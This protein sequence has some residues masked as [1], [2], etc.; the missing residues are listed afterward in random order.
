[1]PGSKEKG[2]VRTRK[3]IPWDVIIIGIITIIML[4]YV[5]IY[6]YYQEMQL[7]YDWTRD[8]LY[9]TQT[10]IARSLIKHRLRILPLFS[11]PFSKVYPPHYHLHPVSEKEKICFKNCYQTWNRIKSADHVVGE[12]ETMVPYP[13]RESWSLDLALKLRFH[14]IWLMSIRMVHI[15][16]IQQILLWEEEQI[17]RSRGRVKRQRQKSHQ[18]TVNQTFHALFLTGNT[19]VNKNEQIIQSAA[20]DSEELDQFVRELV[21]ED[22]LM[23]IEFHVQPVYPFQVPT[24]SLWLEQVLRLPVHAS[25]KLSRVEIL[26]KWMIWKYQPKHYMG[27]C[28]EKLYTHVRNRYEQILDNLL[29]S[30]IG[31]IGNLSLII[32]YLFYDKQVDDE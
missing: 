28:G 6:Y 7:L 24:H 27:Y 5:I 10:K 26:L 21:P 30:H 2:M 11:S 3:F 12:H 16:L 18:Q 13:S 32:D 29:A 31:E 1:M 20:L 4:I 15:S 8:V 19:L 9:R 17:R 25:E 22:K 14:E 23:P